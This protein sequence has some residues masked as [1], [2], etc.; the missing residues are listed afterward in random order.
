MLLEDVATTPRNVGEQREK[1]LHRNAFSVPSLDG[2]YRVITSLFIY[3]EAQCDSLALC[4]RA[5]K[6]KI[7]TR[8]PSN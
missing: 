4:M 5:Q 3:G 7:Q 6:G 2:H 8:D 1:D